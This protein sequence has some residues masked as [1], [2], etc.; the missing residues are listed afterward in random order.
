M[1]EWLEQ[2]DSMGFIGV[3]S[4]CG[5]FKIRENSYAGFRWCLW[6]NKYRNSRPVGTP[7][8]TLEACIKMA[9]RRANQ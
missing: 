5:R 6:E 2:S 9:E 4:S 8:H 1:I 7:A 3:I